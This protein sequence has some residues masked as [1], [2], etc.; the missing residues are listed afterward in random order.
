[1]VET[2]LL[3]KTEKDSRD[4]FKGGYDFEEAFQKPF[5]PARKTAPSRLMAGKPV[6]V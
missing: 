5:L 1:M 6:K 3:A 2:S 4:D